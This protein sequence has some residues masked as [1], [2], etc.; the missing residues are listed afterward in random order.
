ME[1]VP[2]EITDIL[3]LHIFNPKEVPDLIDNYLS[4]CIEKGIYQVRIIHGKGTGIMKRR[5]QWILSPHG[6][7]ICFKDAPPEAGGWGAPLVTLKPDE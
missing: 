3:D 6:Q 7:V 2:I 4:V 5:V 1:P